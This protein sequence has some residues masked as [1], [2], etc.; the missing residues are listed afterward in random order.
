[1]VV[2]EDMIR[3]HDG[4]SH[5][6]VDQEWLVVYVAIKEGKGHVTFLCAHHQRILGS[7]KCHAKRNWV[8]VHH[9]H[10]QSRIGCEAYIS[11]AIGQV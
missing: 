5:M 6:L 4:I 8:D 2:V 1:M 9:V 3:V 7:C 11:A 10:K